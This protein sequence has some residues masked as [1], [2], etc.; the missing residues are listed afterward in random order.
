MIET[1]IVSDSSIWNLITQLESTHGLST[2]DVIDILRNAELKATD[3]QPWAKYEHDPNDSYGRNIIYCENGLEIMI[4]TWEPQDFSAIHNHGHLQWGAVQL[5][6]Y[7][8][9]AIFEY[10]YNMFVTT[11]REFVESSTILGV[12]SSMYHQIGSAES[13]PFLTLHVYGTDTESDSVTHDAEVID[14]FHQQVFL[15]NNSVSYRLDRSVDRLARSAPPVLVAEELRDCVHMCSR[16]L[17]LS[18][19][20]TTSDLSKLALNNLVRNLYCSPRFVRI[21]CDLN[22]IMGYCDVS[23]SIEELMLAL[24]AMAKNQEALADRALLPRFNI[25]TI[26]N[27]ANSIVVILGYNIFRTWTNISYMEF[28]SLIKNATKIHTM[29]VDLTSADPLFCTN[30]VC[31]WICT[32]S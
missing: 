17:T 27:M 20:H 6:G 31:G 8:E 29:P 11:T 21:G 22:S 30:R 9:H 2:A 32:F 7:V 10:S 23:R 26:E 18:A 25:P 3:L 5:F 1:Q 24:C 12:N 4:A 16:V 19:S 15:S 14:L 13:E 28:A